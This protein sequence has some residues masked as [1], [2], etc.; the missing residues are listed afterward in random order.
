[1]AEGNM[2][3]I[4]DAIRAF[5]KKLTT[6]QDICQQKI[7]WLEEE[8]GNIRVLAKGQSEFVT[9]QLHAIASSLDNAASCLYIL[10]KDIQ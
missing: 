9:N 1:M 6:N 4:A 10:L 3:D 7:D 5:P 8:A 2:N